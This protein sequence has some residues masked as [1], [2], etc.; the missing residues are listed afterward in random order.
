MPKIVTKHTVVYGD[1]KCYALL[2]VLAF[3]G[4]HQ[5]SSWSKRP[6]TWI[7]D[8]LAF[9]RVGRKYVGRIELLFKL[10]HAICRL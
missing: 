5:R 8:V 10:Y 2:S 1:V 6:G 3:V 9:C 4:F 7:N